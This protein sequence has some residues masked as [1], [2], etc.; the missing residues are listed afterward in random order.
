MVV[1]VPQLTAAVPGALPASSRVAFERVCCA[2]V[3]V[4]VFVW[5]ELAG[6]A[7]YEQ[8]YAKLAKLLAGI[9]AGKVPVTG[10]VAFASM[11]S[12]IPLIVASAVFEFETLMSPLTAQALS[13]PTSCVTLTV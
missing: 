7:E 4:A 5:L 11:E 3:M 9:V 10:H 12:V 2:Q 8:L 6:A 1:G 13:V